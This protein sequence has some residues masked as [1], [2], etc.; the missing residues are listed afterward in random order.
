MAKKTERTVMEQ[1]SIDLAWSVLISCMETDMYLGVF[2]V[3]LEFLET[4][5]P[6]VTEKQLAEYKEFQQTHAD[7]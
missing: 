4:Y 1:S 7:Y 3:A 5:C 2:D 6:E